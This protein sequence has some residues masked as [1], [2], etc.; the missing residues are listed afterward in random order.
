MPS[1]CRPNRLVE[2]R[3]GGGQAFPNRCPAR[4]IF[5]QSR[6]SFAPLDRARIAN[7]RAR[8]GDGKNGL[9]RSRDGLRGSIIKRKKQKQEERRGQVR[10]RGKNSWLEVG[11]VLRLL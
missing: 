2:G 6:N 5:A 1:R 11:V 7:M 9:G 10:G 3:C 8:G 4:G